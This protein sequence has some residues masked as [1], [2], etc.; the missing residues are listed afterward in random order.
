MKLTKAE[1]NELQARRKLVS[2]ALAKVNALDLY[3]RAYLNGVLSAKGLDTQEKNWDVSL[4]TGK[5]VEKKV[6]APVEAPKA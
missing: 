2:V 5:I 4:K 3:A 6:E 1:L